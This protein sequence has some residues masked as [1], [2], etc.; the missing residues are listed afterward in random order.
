MA[1][2]IQ[3]LERN[4]TVT[5]E[6]VPPPGP[7]A[8][9][10][11]DSLSALNLSLFYG[12]SVATKHV[13]KPHLSALALCT[14]IKQKTGA[15]TILHCTTRDHNTLSLQSLVW[16]AHA[17]GIDTVL[18]ASGDMLSY[19]QRYK[20]TSVRDLDVF[21]LVE[22]ARAAGLCTGVVFDAHPETQGLDRETERLKRKADKGAQFAVTQ[23]VYTSEAAQQIAEATRGAGIPVMLGILPLRT[24]RH[25]E[26]LHERVGGISVPESVRR[27]MHKATDP[28]AEGIELSKELLLDARQSFAGACLMPPF[29]HYE[30]VGNILGE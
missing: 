14:L 26:F 23:P 4:F 6:V 25:A 22:L 29:G 2:L 13:A 30:I 9:P 7:E 21:G 11:L 18:A 17:L 24:P 27:R 16:G 8:G 19:R 28:V 20:T 10:L 15:Q 3:T 5:V 12:Y 1:A